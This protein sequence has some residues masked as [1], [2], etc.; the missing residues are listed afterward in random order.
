MELL[1]TGQERRGLLNIGGKLLHV[2]FG[3]AEEDDVDHLR[4]SLEHTNQRTMEVIHLQKEM[5]TVTR[6]LTRRAEMNSANIKQMTEKLEESTEIF[7]KWIDNIDHKV[8]D[9]EVILKTFVNVTAK[10]QDL[11]LAIMLSLSD[12]NNLL[13]ALEKVSQGKLSVGLISPSEMRALLVRVRSSLPQELGLIA[14]AEVA[15]PYYQA[16]QTRAMSILGSIKVF[17]DLPLTAAGRRFTLFHAHALPVYDPVTNLATRFHLDGELLLLSEDQQRYA[18]PDTKYLARCSSGEPTI[19]PAELTIFKRHHLSCLSALTA[20]LGTPPDTWVWDI[21]RQTWVYSIQGERRLNSHCRHGGKSE[22]THTIIHG[23]REAKAHAGCMMSTDHYELLPATWQVGKVHLDKWINTSTAPTALILTTQGQPSTKE[24]QHLLQQVMRRGS[25]WQGP[26][27][28][29]EVPFEEFQQQLE[30]WDQEQN[31][32]SRTAWGLILGGGALV[33]TFLAAIFMRRH[34]HRGL[35]VQS[36]TGVE[37]SA[38]DDIAAAT[39]PGGAPNTS[40]EVIVRQLRESQLQ[41]DH[42]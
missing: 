7:A 24:V 10:L 4:L 1:P 6:K 20:I 32:G 34:L 33:A 9:S 36:Q 14:G 16:A 39:P 18:E 22:V 11:E 23:L 12:L 2:I 31:N 17:V 13:A 15:Y 38:K 29:L 40:V 35:G 37:G 30:R 25:Y 21:P 41:D 5:L 8:S 3:T 19:C 26:A 28:L 42:I 27:G